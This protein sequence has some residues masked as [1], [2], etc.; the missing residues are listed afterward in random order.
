M[1]ISLNIK[2]VLKA[3]YSVRFINRFLLNRRHSM[4]EFLLLIAGKNP[5]IMFLIYHRHFL[6][7]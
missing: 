1:L 7:G 5:G 3:D 4:F 6:S 2:F